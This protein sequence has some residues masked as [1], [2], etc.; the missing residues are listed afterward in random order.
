MKKRIVSLALAAMLSVAALSANVLAAENG[1]P[2]DGNHERWIISC[3]GETYSKIFKHTFDYM[4]YE[5][6]C[7]YE[8]VLAYT[9]KECERCHNAFYHCWSHSHGYRGH[10]DVCGGINAEE[11]TCHLR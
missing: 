5:K 7:V 3:S 11:G 2:C 6:T 9:N 4:G 8:Y 1:D 10:S